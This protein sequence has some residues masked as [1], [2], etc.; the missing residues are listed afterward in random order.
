MGIITDMVLYSYSVSDGTTETR[1]NKEHVLGNLLIH[2][3]T[4]AVSEWI[5]NFTPHFIMEVI[6]L[7]Y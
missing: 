3:K 6:I 4:W 5:S 7:P 2:S 1:D